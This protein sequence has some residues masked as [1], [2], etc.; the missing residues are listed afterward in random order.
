LI[1]DVEI[2]GQ[3]LP[4]APRRRVLSVEDPITVQ[5]VADLLGLHLNEVGLISMNGVQSEMEN[6]VPPGARLCFFPYLSGG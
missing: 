6:P 2:F 3:L 4:E 5:D 1:I